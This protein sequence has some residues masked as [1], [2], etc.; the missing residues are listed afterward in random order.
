MTSVLL[1]IL[2]CLSVF[3]SD[4]CG[5]HLLVSVLLRVLRLGHDRSVVSDLLQPDVLGVPAAHH[6]H[7]GQ[8]RV[9]GDPAGAASALYERTEL[10]GTLHVYRLGA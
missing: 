5:S 4:V 10:R 2:M 1:L 8:R 7:V 3:C 6:C 9:R